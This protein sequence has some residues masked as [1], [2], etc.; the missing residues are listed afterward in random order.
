[1]RQPPGLL[2]ELLHVQRWQIPLLPRK[3]TT[4]HR[5]QGDTTDPGLVAYWRFPKKLS[6]ESL[7]L[8]HYVIL[9]RPRLLA[10]I[11]SHGLP[12][13]GAGVGVGV[14]VGVD[15]DVSVGVGVTGRSCL[16]CPVFT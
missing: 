8:A 4:L 3:Q 15:V 9:S 12:Y 11:L 1:M 2:A 7:W 14:D 5:V 6:K 10:N 16:V 13:C